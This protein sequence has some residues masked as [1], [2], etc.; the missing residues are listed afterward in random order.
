MAEDILIE[1]LNEIDAIM[2]PKEYWDL[3]NESQTLCSL[4]VP[5]SKLGNS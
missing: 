5:E 1:M 3:F 2:T 4:Q